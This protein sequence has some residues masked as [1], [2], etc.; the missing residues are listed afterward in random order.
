MTDHAWSDMAP[1]LGELA[2]SAAAATQPNGAND[3]AEIAW[4]AKLPALQYDRERQ[5]AADRLGCRV[6]I[7]DR[8]VN[9]AR[10]S[11]PASGQGRPLDLP[12]PEPWSD[13]V[14]GAALL[15]ELAAAIRRHVVIDRHEADTVALWA[16]G[17]HAF[18]AWVIFPR[19][20][21]TAPEKQ[22]GKS[23]LLD[24]VSRLV[25]RRLAASDITPASL[26]RAIEVSRPTMLL[27]EADAYA[28]ENEELRAVL[29]AGHR[30]DGAVI[31]CVGDNY[32]PR[33]FSAWAPVA[34]AAI[35]H[36]PGTI[37]DR[38]IIVRL[39]RRRPDETFEP[40]RLDRAGAL[41]VLAR[42]AARWA[43]DHRTELA[44][45]DPEM[46]A[47]L[48][49]RAADNW[50]P[51]LA[52]ADLAGGN[53]PERAWQAALEL[54]RESGEGESARELML[55]D[56]R[57]LFD[58]EPRGV[59]FTS[60]ILPRLHTRDDRPWSEWKAGKAMTGRHMAALL[61]PLGIST[62][63]TVRRGADRGKGYRAEDFADA[64]SRYLPP[65]R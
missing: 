6:G 11:G 44:T 58:A 63:Q 59:M 38:S 43:A 2:D 21:V 34:L 13:L 41:D 62:N 60:E 15:D 50:R 45:A 47:G 49:N 46:P 54:T 3:D 42:K 35:G 22:C 12:D 57:E 8:E 51:L 40:L 14:E 17:T 1:L 25:P 7:L 23:T 26:F 30:R 37:E 24:V 33:R 16:L 29:N 18:D 65:A 5:A 56:L 61:K 31:R 27:D 19:L 36:L 20:F 9:A 48:Y 4:L 39:R 10:G 28:R 32:E 53:C 55:A 64:W 52:I